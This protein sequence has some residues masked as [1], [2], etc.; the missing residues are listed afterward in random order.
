VTARPVPPSLSLAIHNPLS[1]RGEIRFF[2]SGHAHGYSCGSGRPGHPRRYP[3]EAAVTRATANLADA[4]REGLIEVE[5]V[6]VIVR[7]EDGTVDVRQGRTGVG[8]AAVGGAM[9]GG[10][11]GLIFLAPLLG[12]AVGALAGGAAWK[13]TFGEAGVAE[14]FVDELR[15]SLTPGS[16]ALVLLVREMAP[17]K[18]LPQIREHGRVIQTSLSDKVEAQLAAAL[19]AASAGR[20]YPRA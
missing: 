19:A 7:D 8:A 9:W 5:D 13:S 10:L 1:H 17:D 3:D 12:M 20:D 11:I 2:G 18:I 4:I 16:A 14:S 6:V 15:E